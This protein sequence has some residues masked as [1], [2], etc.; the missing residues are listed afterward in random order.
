MIRNKIF[1]G[2]TLLKLDRKTEAAEYFLQAS[3]AEA[4]SESDRKQIEDAKKKHEAATA[5]G[6]W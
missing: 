3:K 1:I 4:K 2:D 5:T 6:W